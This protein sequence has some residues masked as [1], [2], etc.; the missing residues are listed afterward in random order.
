MKNSYLQSLIKKIEK[1]TRKLIY[2]DELKSLIKNLMQENYH[3]T[4]AY[5]LIYYLKNKWYL[6][7]LKK[8]IFY[9]K[10]PDE[11]YDENE[12]VE[13]WYRSILYEHCRS[14]LH[15]KRYIWGLKALEIHYNNFE[16]PDKILIVN[17]K[18]QSQEMALALQ[19]I[20]FKKYT[21]RWNNLFKKFKKYTKKTKIWRKIFAVANKELA[22]LECMFNH[23]DMFNK[24]VYIFVKKI[25]KRSTQFD[26]QV[27][28]SLIKMGKHH[29]S[30]NRLYQIAKENNKT[31]A[32]QLAE[33][34]KKYSFFLDV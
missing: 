10:K 17:E 28:S 2:S 25:I 6:I 30:I 34:I 5:K 9:V 20:Q 22:L 8:N 12:I 21:S 18:K 23:D 33:I 24:E 3:D 19:A 31:F 27:I 1:K 14:T 16:I 4:K 29:T 32:K 26:I 11:I 7:S 13:K 15:T